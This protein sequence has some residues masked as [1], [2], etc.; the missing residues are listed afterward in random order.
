MCA[1][2]YRNKLITLLVFSVVLAYPWDSLKVSANTTSIPI[3]GALTN[4]GWQLD[5]GYIVSAIVTL[6]MTLGAVALLLY[7]VKGA[8]VWLS[9]G[10][11]KGK[12]EE[13]RNH[14]TNGLIG[15]TILASVFA[16]YSIVDQFFGIG[17]IN[18]QPQIDNNPSIGDGS[19]TT[20]CPPN[21]VCQN[22]QC[23]LDP[24]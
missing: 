21:T 14:L 7:F 9:A 4:I 17:N 20:T 19:C 12:V 2:N 6:L 8:Y 24:L 18:S 23:V 16:I 11:D 5:L 22:K 15:M 1:N 3:K 13:A 10:G